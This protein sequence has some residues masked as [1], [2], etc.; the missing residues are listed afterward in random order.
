M[1]IQID[2]KE[3]KIEVKFI[4]IIDNDKEFRIYKN[5]LG[6]LVINKISFNDESSSIMIIPR[7]S[8][9]IEIK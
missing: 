9:E 1:E 2:R 7:V 8:N 6:E 5:G 4:T 3:E